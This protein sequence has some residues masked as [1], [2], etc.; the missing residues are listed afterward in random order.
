MT[1]RPT[2]I[3]ASQSPARKRLLKRLGYKFKTQPAYIDEDSF[4][5]KSPRALVQT[6]AREKAR[7]IAAKNPRAI[8]I[9]SDQMLV[10][11]R[12]IFGKPHTSKN[13]IR[14][15]TACSGKTVELLTAV[16]LIVPSSTSTSTSQTFL[17]VTRMTFR[18]L[19]QAEIVDYVKTD[20]PLECAGSFMFEKSGIRLFS[21]IDTS[22][23]TAIE[24]LPTLELNQ[25]LRHALNA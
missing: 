11:G 2:I 9:G 7:A 1:A 22:D 18:K 3:L 13:A 16:T 15:L 6:L 10:L 12:R 24:G 17:N 20:Q 21:A 4:K 23:P 19:T 14:Q 8:V 25:R 5:A